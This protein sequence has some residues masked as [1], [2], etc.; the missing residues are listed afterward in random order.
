LEKGKKSGKGEDLMNEDIKE[1][2]QYLIDNKLITIQ[3][4]Y[5]V[6]KVLKWAFD[7]G[8]LAYPEKVVKFQKEEECSHN[9][10]WLS[11]SRTDIPRGY[12]TEFSR[13]DVFYCSKCTKTKI[14]EQH[15][16]TRSMPGWY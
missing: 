8:Y 1:M 6:G 15:A 13:S 4:A 2:T 3:N 5:E 16:I 9:Y 7:R 11:S 14:N 10:I 12:L